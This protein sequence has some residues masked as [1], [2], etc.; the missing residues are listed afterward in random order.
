MKIITFILCL[1]LA[2]CSSEE[3]KAEK[4]EKFVLRDNP[5]NVM[6]DYSLLSSNAGL[7]SYKLWSERVEIYNQKNV[8]QCYDSLI[9]TF[10]KKDSTRTPSHFI[11]S[12]NGEWLQN[13]SN[14]KAINKVVVLNS[15][16]RKLLTDT[17][18][19]DYKKD[20]IYSNS[21][22]VFITEA[23]SLFGRKFES[24]SDLTD[25]KIFTVTGRS[26]RD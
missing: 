9:V 24:N 26:Y 1:F 19:Y 12:V 25:I 14:F 7:R 8:F 3:K 10:Y 15:E 4:T 16:G 20:L 5:D 11:H 23:D 13:S 2:A 22:V 21:D 6:W 17:L 18:Y